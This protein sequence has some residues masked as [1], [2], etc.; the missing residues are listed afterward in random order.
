MVAQIYP[1]SVPSGGLADFSVSITNHGDEAYTGGTIEFPELMG[2]GPLSLARNPYLTNGSY[3]DG[4]WRLD[5]PIGPGETASMYLGLA[6]EDPDGGVATVTTTGSLTS[7][8]GPVPVSAPPVVLTIEPAPQSYMEIS[9]S[10]TGPRPGRTAVMPGERL[11]YH[12]EVTNTSSLARPIIIGDLLRPAPEVAAHDLASVV[13]GGDHDCPSGVPDARLLPS[14]GDVEAIMW[15]AGPDACTVPGGGTITMDYEATVAESG[16]GRTIENL[17]FA[18]AA[19]VS[20]PAARQGEEVA[21]GVV[22]SDV[23]SIVVVQDICQTP[24]PTPVP[25][26]PPL[27]IQF[28]PVPVR[29]APAATAQQDRQQTATAATAAPTARQDECPSPPAPPETA[30]PE[31]GPPE[32]PPAETAV[33]TPSAQPVAATQPSRPQ[34]AVTGV[35]QNSLVGT[36][37]AA[38]ACL[39]GGLL[40]LRL[41]QRRRDH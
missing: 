23:N 31:A 9:K 25:G 30:P 1:E 7:E 39:A 34:L 10:I 33:Q 5:A 26:E 15:N 32:E 3:S 19:P 27:S 11:G 41:T 13:I 40:L 17:A 22:Q 16:I 8:S 18:L 36:L 35:N 4:V 24:N 38:A 28:L 20:E 14:G 6:V 21:P 12:V 2:S 29:S 37:L